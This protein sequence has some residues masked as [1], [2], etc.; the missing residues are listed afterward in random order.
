MRSCPLRTKLRS[1]ER[2]ADAHPLPTH[3]RASTTGSGEGRFQT[4][5]GNRHRRLTSRTLDGGRN[6]IVR[7]DA[8]GP[9]RD[10]SLVRRRGCYA[11]G[12]RADDRVLSGRPGALRRRAPLGT[13]RARLPASGSSKP[14]EVRWREAVRSTRHRVDRPRVRSPRRWSRRLTCPSVPASSS[15]SS[16]WAHLTA[17]ARFRAGPPGPYPAGYPGRPAGGAGHHVPVSRR[18]SA[19]GG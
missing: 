11:P 14:V 3:A 16:R 18:L 5:P 8:V 6:A 7:P 17:S 4:W 19:A 1:G 2:P 13:G 9:A 15:S 12:G 10:D